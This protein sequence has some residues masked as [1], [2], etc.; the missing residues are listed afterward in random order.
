MTVKRILVA[1]IAC[2]LLAFSHARAQGTAAESVA[3]PAAPL[4]VFLN[5]PTCDFDYIRTAIPW[6]DYVR[7][8]RQAQVHL[9]VTI[10]RTA[11]GGTAYTIAFLGR[12]AFQGQADTLHWTAGLTATPDE[13]RHGVTH[14]L[15]LWVNYS[16]GSA[17]NNVVFPRFTSSGVL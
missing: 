6:V 14:L 5:C 13:I 10:L 3:A 12:D 4:R 15:Q 1:G 7:D 16:F 17:F 2:P 9:L 11:P 8:P